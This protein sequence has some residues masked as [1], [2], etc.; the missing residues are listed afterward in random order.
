MLRDDTTYT[1][2][3]AHISAITQDIS[4]FLSDLH[5]PEPAHR[6]D[7]RVA[8]HA[9]CSL[10]HAQKRSGA[11]ESLLQ[12][13]GFEVL[14]PRDAHLCCGAAGSYTLLQPEMSERLAQNK[15]ENLLALQPDFIATGNIG[16]QVQIAGATQTPT[17]HWVQLLDMALNG[18]D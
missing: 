11:V 4:E 1:D 6:Q 8:Y 7:V 10:Q 5:F 2:D 16:C 18:P 3:A 9:A 12:K 13:A 14:I 17:L 15:A